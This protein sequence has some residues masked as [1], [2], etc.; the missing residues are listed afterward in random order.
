MIRR[1]AALALLVALALPLRADFRRV[2]AAIEA[3]H[4]VKRVDIPLMGLMRFACWMVHPKGVYDFQLATFENLRGADPNEF[5][6]LMKEQ[7][8]EGYRPMVQ[9]RSTPRGEFTFIYVKPTPDQR[10]VELFILTHDRSDTVLIRLEADPEI[11]AQEVA[12]QRGGV[13]VAWNR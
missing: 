5:A 1:Y 12:R 10:R 2:A 6:A 4:G 8:G 13:R 3:R 9:V 11:A 7:V